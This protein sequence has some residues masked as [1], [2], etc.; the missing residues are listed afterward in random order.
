MGGLD[1]T[2]L[3]MNRDKLLVSLI[4]V[5]NIVI[6]IL[7]FVLEKKK[8]SYLKPNSTP[9]LPL[10]VFLLPLNGIRLQMEALLSLHLNL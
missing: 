1:I 9:P 8:L 6:T 4:I 2:L 3:T 5:L 7:V 10:L